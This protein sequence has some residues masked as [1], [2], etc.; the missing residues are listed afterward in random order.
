MVGFDVLSGGH[1]GTESGRCAGCEERLGDRRI[2]LLPA[3]GQ[4]VTATTVRDL[5]S[6]AIIA[7]SAGASAVIHG[8]PAPAAATGRQTLEKSRALTDGTAWLMPLGMCVGLDSRQGI[9]MR[10]PI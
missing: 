2:D 3:D 1:R 4:T 7:G 8:Q 5:A 10:L 6:G 9:Q